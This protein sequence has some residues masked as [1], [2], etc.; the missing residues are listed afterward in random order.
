[1]ETHRDMEEDL[2]SDDDDVSVDSVEVDSIL[3][4]E[5]DDGD[6]M[7]Y[8]CKNSDGSQ[9]VYDRSDLMDD[10]PTQRL[11][12]AFE[13]RDVPEWDAV[14]SFCSGESCEECVCEE[15]DRPM[16][17]VRGINYGCERHPVV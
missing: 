10:G 5:Y 1:M 17:H 7:C 12:M 8:M 9:E 3:W 16:R 13:R 15:C 14:C 11:V 4:R 6:H 2:S